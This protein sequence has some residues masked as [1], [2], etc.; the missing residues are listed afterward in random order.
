MVGLRSPLA[1]RTSLHW[2]VID[3]FR[4]PLASSQ[5]GGH[6][7]PSRGL[8]PGVRERSE[9]D[10][11]HVRRRLPAVTFESDSESDLFT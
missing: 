8:T 7:D 5:A 1:G 2:T 4:P 10:K 6:G 9:I 11:N 3:Y